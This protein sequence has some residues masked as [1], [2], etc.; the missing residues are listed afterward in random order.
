MG[1]AMPFGSQSAAYDSFN[2]ECQISLFGVQAKIDLKD[3][4]LNF[5]SIT[6]QLN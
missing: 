6:N 4:D 5:C 2:R 3:R 1:E